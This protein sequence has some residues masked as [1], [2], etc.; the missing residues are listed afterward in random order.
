M[1][2]SL[3]ESVELLSEDSLLLSALRKLS[4]G[5]SLLDCAIM[6][7]LDASGRKAPVQMHCKINS[8]C[9]LGSASKSLSYI[10]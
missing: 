7:D 10:S 8:S 1:S 6:P 3:D 2:A 5:S 9:L 4:G